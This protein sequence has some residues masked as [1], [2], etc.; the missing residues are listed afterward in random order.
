MV[1]EPRE[2]E[3]GEAVTFRSGQFRRDCDV[4]ERGRHDSAMIAARKSVIPE[5]T[6]LGGQIR[7]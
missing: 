7:P 5:S 2:D 4:D 1:C 6:A 3:H